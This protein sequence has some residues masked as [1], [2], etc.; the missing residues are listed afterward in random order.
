MV[1]YMFVFIFVMLIARIYP[2]VGMAY[3]GGRVVVGRYHAALAWDGA[4][5]TSKKRNHL[6]FVMGIGYPPT[7]RSGSFSYLFW[8]NGAFLHIVGCVC[9]TSVV[10]G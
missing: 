10:V 2:Y 9:A 7:V 4:V 8:R 1:C 5:G 6:V 3:F